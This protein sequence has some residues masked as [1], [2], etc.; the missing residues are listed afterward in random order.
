MED[1]VIR[2]EKDSMEFILS[3]TD[4]SISMYLL[5][6]EK[7]GISR[8][9]LINL[10]IDA[11]KYIHK[12]IIDSGFEGD[13]ININSCVSMIIFNSA[14]KAYLKTVDHMAKSIGVDT[15]TLL[16]EMRLDELSLL[17]SKVK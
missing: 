6:F 5:S 17:K 14:M 1:I 12:L 9:K 13:G 10:S 3:V 15:E 4:I 7:E 8:D 11:S 2:N 16:N